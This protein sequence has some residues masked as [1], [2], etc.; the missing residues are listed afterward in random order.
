MN[1]KIIVATHKPYHMPDDPMYLPVQCG[2]AGKESIGYQRDDEGDNISYQNETLS[3]LTA[4][5]RLNLTHMVYKKQKLE[6]PKQG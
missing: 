6:Y 5:Y 3:E 1:I 2:A 4:L